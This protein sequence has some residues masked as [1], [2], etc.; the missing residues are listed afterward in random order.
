MLGLT[1]TPCVTLL[2]QY[3]VDETNS[4]KKLSEAGKSVLF[5]IGFVHR[6][7]LIPR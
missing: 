5:W 6:P 3:F 1:L 4:E 7:V 2:P